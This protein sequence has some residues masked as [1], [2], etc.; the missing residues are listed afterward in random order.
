MEQLDKNE[1]MPLTEEEIKEIGF[2]P[3]ELEIIRNAE[4]MAQTADILPE[5]PDEL[6]AKMEKL[7]PG[8]DN[9][10]Q[11]FEKLNAL[12]KTNPDLLI[13]M[14]ALSEVT[15]SAKPEKTQG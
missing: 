15:N 12:G 7:F 8:N 5:D 1:F 4:A 3:E 9:L 2:T 13:Q 11:V 14:V 10:N 6:Y